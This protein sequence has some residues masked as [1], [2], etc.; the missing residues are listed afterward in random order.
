MVYRGPSTGCSRCRDRH[1]RCDTKRPSCGKCIR[2]GE[3]CPGYEDVGGVVFKD[4]T[5]Q[6][7]EKQ[8]RRA[9]R[10]ECGSLAVVVSSSV[11]PRLH[12]L[13]LSPHMASVCFFARQYVI[14][15]V[16]DPS[17]ARN[18]LKHILPAYE[19]ASPTSALGTVVPVMTTKIMYMCHGQEQALSLHAQSELNAVRAVKTAILDPEERTRDETLLAI[20][21]LG[22]AASLSGR[23]GVRDNTRLHADGALALVCQRGPDSFYLATL[24]VLVRGHKERCSLA[25]PVVWR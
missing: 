25:I 5:R 21:C 24:T 2:R 3:T 9:M 19:S 18:F 17:P 6:V 22:F 14:P 12:E 11:S 10:A 1:V 16:Q 4:L 13:H 23:T 8:K 20:L 7:F 15:T